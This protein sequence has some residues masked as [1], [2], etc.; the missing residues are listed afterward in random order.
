MVG[1]VSHEREKECSRGDE[2]VFQERFLCHRQ[3]RGHE[4]P[5][6]VLALSRHQ[7]ADIIH[8]LWGHFPGH[9]VAYG[10]VR[11]T[12]DDGKVPQDVG[13][14]RLNNILTPVTLMSTSKSFSWGLQ[15]VSET[16]QEK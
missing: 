14:Q 6:S 10:G 5:E 1:D 13:S 9:L 11:D 4:T 15:A 3:V 16:P 8:V 12:L 7:V 2:R